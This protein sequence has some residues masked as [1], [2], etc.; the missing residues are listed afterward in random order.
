MD[1][2]KHVS[3][4]DLQPAGLP[5]LQHPGVQASRPPR[6]QASS[7]QASSLQP[8]A[9]SLQPPAC[10][11]QRLK[12]ARAHQEHERM[13]QNHKRAR[14]QTTQET[15]RRKAKRRRRKRRRRRRSAGFGTRKLW[16]PEKLTPPLLPLALSPVQDFV[17]H[18]QTE[19]NDF[20][21]RLRPPTSDLDGSRLPNDWAVSVFKLESAEIHCIPN[22]KSEA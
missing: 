20:R 15:T 12:H 2:V 4:L 11:L 13:H 17:S 14:A 9:F 10:S 21:V 1:L 7:L 5:S 18:A 3:L 16:P 8:Q 19:Q 6:L 22:S